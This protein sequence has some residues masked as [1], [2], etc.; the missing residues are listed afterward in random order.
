MS[1]FS[2]VVGALNGGVTHQK[3]GDE[4]NDVVQAVIATRKVGELTLKLKVSPNGEHGVM[5]SEDIKTKVPELTRGTS[6]FFADESGNLLRRDP[7]QGE[8]FRE[9]ADHETGELRRVPA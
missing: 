9:V 7:R 5:I 4:L 3:L 1:T 2:D 6:A 8:M